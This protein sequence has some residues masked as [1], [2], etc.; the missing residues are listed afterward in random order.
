MTAPLILYAPIKG[1]A[2]PLAEVPDP[3]FS[4]GMLGEGLA[5]DPT[6]D[7]LHAPFDG[8][9]VTVAATRHAVGLK[10]DNGVE[11]LIHVGLETVALGGAGFELAVQ[12]GQ[13]VA[14]GERL[15]RFDLD[16][17]ARRAR[18]LIT[19]VLVTDA[20]G[21]TVSLLALDREVEVGEPL[22]ELRGETTAAAGG[23]VGEFAELRRPLRLELPHG[24]HARP[25]GRL[26]QAAKGFEAEIALVMGE[27]RANA[28]SP[29]ALMGLGLSASQDV[30][31]SARGPDAETALERLAQVLVEGLGETTA[32]PERPPVTPTVKVEAPRRLGEIRGVTGA[33]G[34]AVGR[35]FRLVRAEPVVI[36]AGVGAAAETQALEAAL[37]RVRGELAREAAAARGDP[38][39]ILEAHMEL[40]DDAELIAATRAPIASGK[41][42][43]FA[44]DGVM[45]AHAAQLLALDDARLKGRA[46]DLMDLR[47]RV[48]LALDGKTEAAFEPPFLDLGADAIVLADD[49]LPS[50]IMTLIPRVAGFCTALG[51]PTSHVAILCAGAGLPL[52][53][54]AG[55]AVL[56]IPD[57]TPVIL[58]AGQGWLLRDPPGE[59]LAKARAE[60]ARR[61]EAKVEA[62]RRAGELCRTRDGVRIEVFANLGQAGE[63]APAVALGAE[64]CGLLRTEFLFLERETA[65]GEDEQA[66]VYQAVADGLV[67]RPLVIRTL[68][69]GGDKP[70]P[71][72]PLPVEQ[73]PALGLRGVRT[74]LWRPEL[75]RTQLRA[76]LR[77][78][79]RGQCK[80]MVPMVASLSELVAVRAMLDAV[81]VELGVTERVELGVMVETPAA[82]VTTGILAQAADFFSIG[83]ND[84]TQYALA[85]DRGNPATATELDALHPGVL[86]L[87]AAAC[88][89][90][91][92]AGRWI[93]V[94]GA[95]ASD[96]LAAPL[97]VGL[98]VTELSAAPGA[99]PELKA[100]LRGVSL[101]ACRSLARQA[102][103]LASAAEVRV[104]LQRAQARA[105]ELEAAS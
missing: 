65:P 55:E 75:L 14:R 58:D 32:T 62:A 50:E 63:A 53:V 89:G 5:I 24:L 41:S 27:R 37:V 34:L 61:G 104:L 16:L 74:S 95:L 102:L 13:R 78:R 38:R 43:G 12:V 17:L 20:A 86:R 97:L 19:P 25:A 93:G 4:G 6:G 2:A 18:S 60:L 56:A 73:N 92:G 66:A 83:A 39:E 30:L 59:D 11:V 54:A 28:K 45:R 26:A 67:G 22:I 35:A 23:E 57:G 21:C 71:Y 52:L 44:W 87:M 9:V 69:I 85:M 40:L 100:R 49:L 94:C 47:R 81:R 31:L 88:E 68:D 99:V 3:A 7:S 82:A 76:I 1:W 96:P 103:E 46:A 15:G 64:G 72:L 105:S 80:I 79:P 91:I 51:G 84:L 90:A 29:V 8:V 101:E 36:E 70:T 77:V 48:L 33:P 42:A 10:A 98:G